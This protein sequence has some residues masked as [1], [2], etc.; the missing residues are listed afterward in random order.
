M[1]YILIYIYVYTDMYMYV[2]TGTYILEIFLYSYLVSLI[3][4]SFI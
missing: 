1:I 3:D 4:R 2:Y